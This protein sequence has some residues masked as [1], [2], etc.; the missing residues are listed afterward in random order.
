M[1]AASYTLSNAT[2]SSS[3]TTV[4][5]S[6]SND[7][8]IT[9]SNNKGWG[10]QN[11]YIKFSSGTQYTVAGI[12][13]SERIVSVQF[14]GYMNGKTEAWTSD[15]DLYISEFNGSSYSINNPSG[16]NFNTAYYSA[17]LGSVTFS[18]LKIASGSF[19]FTPQ[20]NQLDFIIT[21]TTEENT[22]DE[23]FDGS[24]PYTWNF[25]VEAGKWTKS[26]RQIK[27]NTTDWNVVVE[28]A[29]DKEARNIST[30]ISNS[31]IDICKGLSFAA[32][33]NSVCL[34]WTNA[35]L[36][37][38]GKLTIPDLKVGMKVTFTST[39]DVTA[40]EDGTGRVS[41]ASGK[42]FTVST[43]G[44]VTFS[45][46]TYVQAIAVTKTDIAKIDKSGSWSL[47]VGGSAQNIIVVFRNASNGILDMSSGEWASCTVTNADDAICTVAKG[48]HDVSSGGQGRGH[49]TITP[50]TAGSSTVTINFP[51]SDRYNAK[52]S[53]IVFTVS[54]TTQTISFAED[55]KTISYGDA[56]P[57]NALTQTPAEGGGAVTYNSSDEH[58]AS[59]NATTGALTI[60]N[61]GT[62]TITATAAE[63]DNYA[64]ATASYTLTVN[65]SSTPTLTWVTS[66]NF[67][68][69]DGTTLS[70]GNT[71][72]C[73]A[74]ATGTT[75]TIQYRSSDTKIAGV[76]LDTYKEQSNV[77]K[78]T[79]VGNGEVT[80]TAYV[81]GSG[82]VNPA[83]VSFTMTI[84]GREI[85]MSFQ[86]TSGK[87]KVGQTITPY[88]SV[89]DIKLE[90]ITSIT[91]TT[92]DA[93]KAT[94]TAGETVETSSSYTLTKAN[95]GFTSYV[96]DAK[97]YLQYIYATIKGEAVT[98]SP[99]NIT[100]TINSDI[101][102]PTTTTYQ[103]TVTNED[104]NFNW[105]APSQEYTLY[106]GDYMI[107]PRIT[108]NASGNWHFSKGSVC[109]SEHAYL[110]DIKNG[111]PTWNDK[112]FKIGEGVPDYKLY[113]SDGTSDTDKAYL[114]WINGQGGHTDTLMVYAK[115]AGTVKLRA[116]D[117]QTG[118]APADLTINIIDKASTLTSQAD[119]YVSAMHF[120]YT[121]S[122]VGESSV[123]APSPNYWED[124]GAYYTCGLSTAFNFDYCDEDNDGNTGE[125]LN[126]KYFVD[127]NGV[128]PQFYGMTVEFGNSGGSDHS[129]LR[130]VDRLRLYKY[131]ST[132]PDQPLLQVVGGSHKIALPTPGA[133]TPSNYKLIIKARSRKADNPGDALLQAYWSDSKRP[134]CS[135]TDTEPTIF[136]VDVTSGDPVKELW[137]S[138]VDIYWIAFS[139]EVKNVTKPAANTN[140]TYAASTYAYSEAL[141][142]SKSEEANEGLEAYYASGFS[143]G[144]DATAGSA[145]VLTRMTTD[146]K[147]VVEANTGLVL[148]SEEATT[149]YMIVHA[150]NAETPTTPYA[151]DN[152]TA[153]KNYLVAGPGSTVASTTGTGDNIKTNFVMS[154]QYKKFTED[155][156]Q[157]VSDYL[158]DRDWSFYKILPSANVPTSNAYLSIPGNLYVNKN[159]QIVEMAS[160]AARAA[161][162]V[163]AAES[164]DETAEAPAS[165]L[166]L[167]ILF[168]ETS[169]PEETT[170]DP[171]SEDP[172]GSEDGDGKERPHRPGDGTWPKPVFPPVI[173]TDI[174][175]VNAE[176]ADN[177]VWHSMEGV[178]VS[179]PTKPGLYI[180]NGKKVLVK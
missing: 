6:F 33:A 86:P 2:Y 83:E 178:R 19:T 93:S 160:S 179:Q 126:G 109:A 25:A 128:M 89:P 4:E 66:G 112:D 60:N 49:I 29:T 139:T 1:W 71:A 164:T 62:C 124:R 131:D 75:A 142:L 3:T 5:W 69:L 42:E 51:G 36:W 82:D 167:D 152:S 174:D 153:T 155:E 157:A 18:N 72:W 141:D 97:E 39:A 70:Y 90:D 120:P 136:S 31:S 20:G 16:N 74:T 170:D 40:T 162:G 180:R 95:G 53:E 50:L 37:M 73:L 35:C 108:G 98:E 58:V 30:T 47:V 52:S 103:V 77:C 148:K 166:M 38:N 27:E 84:E 87:V 48:I 65:G 134:Y 144:T 91:V 34:D 54:K 172:E 129:Y 22:V 168:Q 12:P 154:I 15:T 110:Y 117:S 173:I 44:N 169:T 146:G 63:N 163:D 165:K 7:L 113:A 151:F 76:S 175:S 88:I 107:I 32:T 123:A 135:F 17:N 104:L 140:L 156:S 45:V 118:A 147:P 59:V 10:Q 143:T 171:E 61:A 176:T 119:T 122:F 100:V 57:T 78:I 96:K 11:G 81:E 14:E 94:V 99:V 116:K 21:I 101:Y 23:I 130:K 145:V 55:S 105:A 80:I 46:N 177:A 132:K 92:V 68:N 137:V 127:A 133:G 150:L 161:F 13:S 64:E 56:A 125:A 102:K 106:T 9:N 138:D 121:W 24:Y 8:T 85:H 79:P 28:S 41:E 43:A 114:V 67:S 149:N 159:G 115:T 158:Y 111:T 26:I